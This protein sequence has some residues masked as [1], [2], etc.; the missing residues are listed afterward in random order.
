MTKEARIYNGQ[1]TVPS[2]SG[3]CWD[4]WTAICKRMKLDISLTP[5]TKINPKWIKDKIRYYNTLR[6]K[7]R[8]NTLLHK[9][10]QYLLGSTSQNNENKK[11]K[12]NA[13]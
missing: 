7:H 9:L 5:Y 11:N 2:I 1:K 3:A 6:G 13:T 12:T 8:L 10:Q 4:K